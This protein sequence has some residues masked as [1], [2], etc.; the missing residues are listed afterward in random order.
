MVEWKLIKHM[1]LFQLQEIW[2]IFTDIY[3]YTT[4]SDTDI[5]LF[6]ILIYYFLWYWY[7][8]FLILIYYFSDTDI[9]LFVIL[10]Y[11]FFWYWYTTFSDTNTL[12]FLILMYY[13]S[14]WY[15]TFS[16]ILSWHSYESQYN[17]ISIS[18]YWK[19]LV[20]N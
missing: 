8:T 13:F 11:C 5:L 10:I 16:G 18:I 3:W 7:T 9:L 14:D 2:Y 6:V 12:L 15:T 20:V 17:T 1:L 4:F 19:C